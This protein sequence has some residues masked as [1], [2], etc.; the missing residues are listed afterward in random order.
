[1]S[2]NVNAVSPIGS[3]SIDETVTRRPFL[4]YMRRCCPSIPGVCASRFASAI[5]TESRTQVRNVVARDTVSLG[6]P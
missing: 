4:Q 3:S 2:V 5:A 6:Y 1:M